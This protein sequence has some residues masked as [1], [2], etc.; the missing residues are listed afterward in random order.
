MLVGDAEGVLP[1]STVFD[2][3]LLYFW[4][5]EISWED[6]SGPAQGVSSDVC[7][8]SLMLPISSLLC[9]LLSLIVLASRPGTL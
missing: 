9:R 8:V 4:P 2:Q 5:R 3:N 6:T 7:V 1:E